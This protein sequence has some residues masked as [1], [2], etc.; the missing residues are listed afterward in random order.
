MSNHIRT[1]ADELKIGDRIVRFG[2]IVNSI[3]TITNIVRDE[4]WICLTFDNDER[5]SM[6]HDRIQIKETDE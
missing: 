4:E 1:R 3:R 5:W 2:E 6:A